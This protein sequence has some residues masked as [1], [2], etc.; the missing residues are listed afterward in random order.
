MNKFVTLIFKTAMPLYSSKNIIR[1][2]FC[3]ILL[4]S[5]FGLSAQTVPVGFSDLDEKVRDLQLLGKIDANQ[6][7]TARPFYMPKGQNYNSLFKAIDSNSKL[8]LKGVFKKWYSWQVLPLSITQKYNDNRAFGWNDQGMVLAK[9]YQQAISTG[10]YARLG[11]L[12]VQLK[13]EW[14]YYSSKDLAKSNQ[15]FPGQSSITI[16]AAGLSFG[17]SSQN[18]WW[19][20]GIY[21]SLLMSN[22]APGFPHLSL[23]TTRPINIGIGKVEFQ[24]VLG[25]LN[26]DTSVGFENNFGAKRLFGASTPLNRQYNGLNVVFQ[27]RNSKSLFLGIT[28]AFQQYENPDSKAP[29]TTKY[30]PVLN[31]LFK[32]TYTDDFMAKDQILSFYTRWLFPKNHAEIYFEYGFNDAKQSLTDLWVDM[33][34]SGAYTFG[35]KKINEINAK[36]Y[37]SLNAEFTKMSQ[38]PSYIQRTAGNWYEHSTVI[39]GFTNLNQILGAASGKGNDLQ[40]INFSW[41]KGF[42]KIGFLFQHIANA[43]MLEAGG[44][45]V[46]LRNTKWDDFVF[47]LQGSYSYKKFIFNANANWVNSKNY[48]WIQDNHNSNLSLNINT[49]YIW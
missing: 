36:A 39:E 14:Y 17:L 20:P 28:R 40:T 30:L 38:T 2:V 27:P 34:H 29:F 26:R 19:G 24:L 8:N 47:G 7:L 25:R 13:P 41:N 43:P 45:A 11:I 9:G 49:V 46:R 22:N 16:R 6:S 1:F 3:T 12:H 21:S 44:N 37:L 4:T 35:F 33:S 32:N 5:Q 10:I 48:N 23:N 18:L 15:F 42:N 31:G